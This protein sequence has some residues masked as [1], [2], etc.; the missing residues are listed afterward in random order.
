MVKRPLILLMIIKF[1][2]FQ[3]GRQFIHDIRR[4]TLNTPSFQQFCQVTNQRLIDLAIKVAFIV[5]R[6]GGHAL[7]S[8]IIFENLRCLLCLLSDFRN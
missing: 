4:L 7:L 2:C 5:F 3:D 8:H 6:R 1:R